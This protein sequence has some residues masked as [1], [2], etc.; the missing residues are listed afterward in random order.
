MNNEIAE[1]KPETQIFISEHKLKLPM[2]VVKDNSLKWS[3]QI[4][5]WLFKAGLISGIK[6]NRFLV[7][8]ENEVLDLYKQRVDV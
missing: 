7:V 2:D 6:T 3:P 5:G 1:C 4:V 8:N